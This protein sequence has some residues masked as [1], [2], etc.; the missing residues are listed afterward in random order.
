MI[1][2][3][4]LLR[5]ALVCVAKEEQAE[6]HPGLTGVHITRQHIE[7]TNGHVLV[8]MELKEGSGAFFDD[9]DP[10]DIDLTVRFC[11]DIPEKA[12]FTE[13]T[14]NNKARAIHLDEDNKAFSFTRLEVIKGRFPDL[15]KAIPT[16]KRDV[17]PCLRLEYLAY[18]YLMFR[19]GVAFM[20]PSGMEAPCRFR[21]S[22]FTNRLYGNPIF[23]VQPLY[24]NA[25]E[26]AE[27]QLRELEAD[28]D[29]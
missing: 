8:R 9:N 24:E 13:I 19:N 11:G 10:T 26:I 15:D 17:I 20:E 14:F 22:P 27:Q 23:I 3:T 21:F 16:E 25:F 28:S 6:K 5:A 7:A 2:D 29:Q 18:P 12:C 1:I 4:N